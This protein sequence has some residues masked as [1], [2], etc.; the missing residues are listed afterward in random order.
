[1][2]VF[3]KPLHPRVPPPRSLLPLS[4]SRVDE[5][6]RNGNLPPCPRRTATQHARRRELVLGDVGSS[7]VVCRGREFDLDP[8]HMPSIRWR[9][10]H[11]KGIFPQIRRGF[12]ISNL[13]WV[14]FVLPASNRSPS[15]FYIN[16]HLSS[17]RGWIFW[18]GKIFQ[19]EITFWFFLS[20][21]EEQKE[22]QGELFSKSLV[23]SVVSE[24]KRRNENFLWLFWFCFRRVQIPKVRILGI[25][26]LGWNF[27]YL[28]WLLRKNVE[29]NTGS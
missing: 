6:I 15:V 14:E 11:Q 9:F 17:K 8:P 27:F 12:Q 2:R 5:R 26:N 13:K 21:V 24:K 7:H 22:I 1:P 19:E 20:V 25:G 28:R 3:Q 16:P 29:I 18:L 23:C 10:W 4:P